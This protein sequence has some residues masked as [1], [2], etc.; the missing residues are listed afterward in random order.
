MA[1]AR[2][3]NQFSGEYLRLVKSK[4]ATMPRF[5]DYLLGML[6]D[7]VEWFCLTLICG[8][9]ILAVHLLY[10]QVSQLNSCSP[11]SKADKNEPGHKKGTV[12]VEEG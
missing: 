7:D 8:C 2:S 12:E 5:V 10:L 3:K 4:A 9:N 6:K 1:V 11:R